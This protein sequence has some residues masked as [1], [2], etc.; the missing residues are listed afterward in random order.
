MISW[1]RRSCWF[2]TVATCQNPTMWETR[3]CSALILTPWKRNVSPKETTSHSKKPKKSLALMKL[4]G[5][6]SKQQL[7]AMSSEPDT[8]YVNSLHRAKGNTETKQRGQRDNKARKQRNE[9]N[10]ATDATMSSHTGDKKC[11]AGSVQCHNCHKRGHFSKICQKRK[12]IHEVQN[13]TGSKQKNDSDLIDDMFLGSHEVDNID[14]SNRNKAFTTV[15]L[16][17]KPYHKRTVP[18][19]CKIDT[20][21]CN[22]QDR[23][24]KDHWELGPPQILTAYGGQK[25]EYIDRK[26]V[27]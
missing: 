22:S 3:S 16:T 12:Q 15:E 6:S 13:H 21:Q 23:V 18:I 11:P 8:I 9:S 5:N 26:S 25:V 4:P 17:A 7:Q 10:Y 24:W 20:G 14:N 1:Q 27:V 2:K 19:V